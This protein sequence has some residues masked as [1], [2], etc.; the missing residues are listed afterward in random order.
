MLVLAFSKHPSI[1]Q[2]VINHDALVW[3]ESE[4]I[5]CASIA[6]PYQGS[7]LLSILYTNMRERR[8]LKLAGFAGSSGSVVKVLHYKVPGLIPSWTLVDFL[9]LSSPIRPC[10]LVLLKQ[11]SCLPLISATHISF[12][13]ILIWRLCLQVCYVFIAVQQ[14]LRYI[15]NYPAPKTDEQLTMN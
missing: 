14:C 10:R 13:L 1:L 15:H 6:N 8:Q 2:I 7:K 3:G 11:P 9:P 12:E 4:S 5:H